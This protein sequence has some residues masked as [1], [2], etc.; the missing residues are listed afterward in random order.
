[1]KK[2]HQRYTA[3]STAAAETADAHALNPHDGGITGETNM[4]SADGDPLSGNI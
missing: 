2:R 3:A 4:A 1:M